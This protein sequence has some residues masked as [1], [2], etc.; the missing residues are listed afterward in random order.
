MQSAVPQAA[1]NSAGGGRLSRIHAGTGEGY[2]RDAL[3][4]QRSIRVERLR[5]GARRHADALAEI[6]EVQY[7]AQDLAVE[8]RP[9]V[10]IR[11]IANAEYASDIENLDR[12]ADVEF[13][14]QV[15]RIAQ[16][17]LAMPQGAHD[18]VTL[19]HGGHTPG[20]EFELVVARLVVQDANGDQH[21]FL[22]RDVG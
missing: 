3:R 20:C 13:R 6:G 7:R 15:T 19:G 2:H 5:A 18:D 16:Q 17:R 11:R 4:V 9:D 10:R 1:D 14:G 21:T 22:A 8:W 12:V